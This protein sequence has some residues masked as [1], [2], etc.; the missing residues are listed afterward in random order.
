MAIFQD[1]KL[2]DSHLHIIDNRF[3]LLP[4]NGFLPGTFTCEDYLGRMNG[5][6]LAGG[7]IVS[8]SLQALDQTCL[9]DALKKLGPAFVGV[10]LD[11]KFK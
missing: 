9:V 6:F 11:I 8:G 1:F 5:Y 2:F 3:P 7:A 10:T 4:N